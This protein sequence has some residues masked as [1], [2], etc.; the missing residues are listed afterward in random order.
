MERRSRQ[1][2]ERPLCPRQGAGVAQ[3][4]GRPGADRVSTGF[5]EHEGFV[6]GEKLLAVHGDFGELDTSDVVGGPD[7]VAVAGLGVTVTANGLK[8]IQGNDGDGGCCIVDDELGFQRLR[9]VANAVGG[10]SPGAA[11]AFFRNKRFLVERDVILVV[12]AEGEGLDAGAAVVG[13]QQDAGGGLEVQHPVQNKRNAAGGRRKDGWRRVDGEGEHLG[14]ADVAQKVFR[15]VGQSEAAF[16]I[17]HDGVGVLDHLAVVDAVAGLGDADQLVGSSQVKAGSGGNKL[18]GAIFVRLHRLSRGSRDEKRC[19]RQ[20][21]NR[22][23][24][25][26]HPYKGLTTKL[27]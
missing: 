17:E 25:K 26:K 13:S 5:A 12:E 1:H 14:L 27:A 18:G 21:K 16:V 11:R 2:P 23:L 10:V 20:S 9:L 3:V 24:H 22:V 7:D 4:V 15:P 19:Q 8:R 6:I